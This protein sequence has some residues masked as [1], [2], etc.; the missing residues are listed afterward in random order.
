MQMI[1]A[2]FFGGEGIGYGYEEYED[3]GG[4]MSQAW[5]DSTWA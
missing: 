5:S 2:N 3:E 1:T 4:M